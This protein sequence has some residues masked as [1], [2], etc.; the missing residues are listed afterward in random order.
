MY[1]GGSYVVDWVNIG[2]GVF[3]YLSSSF[4]PPVRHI[5]LAFAQEV[6]AILLALTQL[7]RT[8]DIFPYAVILKDSKPAIQAV[9]TL[10]PPKTSIKIIHQQ[11]HSLLNLT[12]F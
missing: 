2:T 8:R 11:M 12:K 9:H 10:E 4:Y 5:G 7:D 3:S 6:V 1:V